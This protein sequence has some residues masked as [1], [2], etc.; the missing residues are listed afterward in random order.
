[1]GGW[2]ERRKD[3]LRACL[4]GVAVGSSQGGEG[5]V[6]GEQLWLGSLQSSDI[7]K[8]LSSPPKERSSGFGEQADGETTKGN[9][10]L[11]GPGL[12]AVFCLLFNWEIQ[13]L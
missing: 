3:S 4:V 9:A 11:L 2:R 12:G 6:S 10:H 1:M 7:I 8:T 13:V 5:E